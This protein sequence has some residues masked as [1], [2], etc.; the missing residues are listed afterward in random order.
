MKRPGRGLFP[1]LRLLKARLAGGNR[2]SAPESSRWAEPKNHVS[3]PGEGSGAQRPMEQAEA[4]D[5]AHSGKV[6]LGSCRRGGCGR[7][8]T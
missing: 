1:L 6:R 7:S 8:M 3:A 2:Q 5:I 4:D